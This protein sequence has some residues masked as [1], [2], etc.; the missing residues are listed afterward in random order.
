VLVAIGTFV[1]LI[2]GAIVFAEKLDKADQAS[3]GKNASKNTPATAKDRLLSFVKVPTSGDR[4]MKIA[5][6]IEKKNVKR[7]TSQEIQK[8][9][10]EKSK[11]D[12]ALIEESIPRILNSKQS[13]GEK[14]YSE[15]K[16]HHRWIGIYFFYS[17]SFSRALRVISLA[18]NIIILLFVQSIT[19][20]LTNPDDG[21]C[22]RAT[23]DFE[24][25]KDES[26]YATGEPKCSWTWT[27]ESHTTGG[28]CSF[29]EP[30]GSMKIVL[31]VAVFSALLCT[32][33][34]LSIDWVVRNILAAPLQDDKA[35]SGLTVPATSVVPFSETDNRTEVRLASE[36]NENG[37]LSLTVSS[38]ADKSLQE[39][40]SAIILHRNSL[41]D[42]S[43]IAEFDS[44]FRQ[45]VV[46]NY[47][48]N[49]LFYIDQC[50]LIISS[51]RVVGP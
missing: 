25:L 44:K 19:Y 24:C 20:N 39:L 14:I 11:S 50:G 30:D 31:F 36:P 7:S 27:D 45:Y 28:Q 48:C 16:H 17:A 43:V 29:V 40:Q 49:L 3:T 5:P 4:L 38:S 22:K 6:I 18:T 1:G 21:S 33:I 35:P 41:Q 10:S 13:L 46:V 51:F 2:F 37:R 26:P 8:M 34:G 12:V 23:S 15:M 47:R 32:P 42:P 9:L